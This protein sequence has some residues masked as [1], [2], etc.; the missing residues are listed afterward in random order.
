MCAD[1]HTLMDKDQGPREVKWGISAFMYF[2]IVEQVVED[3]P[4]YQPAREDDQ[5][6]LCMY[7]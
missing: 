3:A 4:H 7:K 5:G 1:L 2:L 6:G